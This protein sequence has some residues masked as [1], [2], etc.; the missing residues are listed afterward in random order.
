MFYK[1]T[2]WLPEAG[3]GLKLQTVSTVPS[4]MGV[5]S[6]ASLEVA[7]IRAMIALSGKAIEDLPDLG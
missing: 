2:G 1:E 6:S 5:S 7:T 4:G 3:K